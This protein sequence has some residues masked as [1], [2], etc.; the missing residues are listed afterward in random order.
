MTRPVWPHDRQC[1]RRASPCVLFSLPISLPSSRML[2]RQT[3]CQKCAIWIG[4]A[5]VPGLFSIYR[6]DEQSWRSAV[7]CTRKKENS[8]THDAHKPTP[9]LRKASQP[10][11]SH[12]GAAPDSDRAKRPPLSEASA[13]G[14]ELSPGDRVEGLGNFGKPNGEFGTVERANDEDAVV[15][16]DG[17]GRNRIHQPSLK[18]V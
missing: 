2:A 8:M 4:R 1:L 13:T 18:K 5:F 14:S 17:D 11:L 9:K 6:V 3:N 10:P 15:K 7:L 12:A 16:W